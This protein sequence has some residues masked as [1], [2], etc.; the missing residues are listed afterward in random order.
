MHACAGDDEETWVLSL[1][2]TQLR[3]TL[4][5]R[6][7]LCGKR[8]SDIEAELKA[9]QT[10]L[11]LKRLEQLK[12]LKSSVGLEKWDNQRLTLL[13]KKHEVNCQ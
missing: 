1:D 7:G 8:L 13:R 3:E 2:T 11:E 12:V 6:L 5:C 10:R 9:E 4:R